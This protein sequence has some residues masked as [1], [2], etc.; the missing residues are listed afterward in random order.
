MPV[1]RGRFGYDAPGCDTL[2]RMGEHLNVG[3]RENPQ[4]HFG[5]AVSGVSV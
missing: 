4:N 1:V 5:A 3:S 2:C